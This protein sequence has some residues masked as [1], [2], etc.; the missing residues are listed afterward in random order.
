M[1]MDKM[2]PIQK[3]SEVVLVYYNIFNKDYQHASRALYTFVPNK[4][5]GQLLDIFF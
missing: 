2:C 5:L 3:F 1:K 4:S